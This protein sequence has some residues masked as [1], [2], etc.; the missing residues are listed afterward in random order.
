MPTAPRTNRRIKPTRRASSAMAALGQ[1]AARKAG[2]GRK[3]VARIRRK[4]SGSQ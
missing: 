3:Q 2:A 4:K 1:G